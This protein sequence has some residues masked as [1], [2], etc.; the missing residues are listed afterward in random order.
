MGTGGGDD[1]GTGGIGGTGGSAH[2]RLL[3]ELSQ[4]LYIE[5]LVSDSWLTLGAKLDVL[6]NRV[7]A[8]DRRLDSALASSAL[9]GNAAAASGSSLSVSAAASLEWGT[10]VKSSTGSSHSCSA[11]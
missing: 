7:L 1:E 8:T 3:V 11:T 9:C 4:G 10:I 5:P 6:L 2:W